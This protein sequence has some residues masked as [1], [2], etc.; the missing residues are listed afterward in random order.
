MNLAK[1][2]IKQNIDDVKFHIIG[3]AHNSTGG[4]EWFSNTSTIQ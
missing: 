3:K 1:S 2:N 4:G